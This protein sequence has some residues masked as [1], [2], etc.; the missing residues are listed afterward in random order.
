MSYS[1]ETAESLQQNTNKLDSL[2]QLIKDI[3]EFNKK[4]KRR[5]KKKRKESSDEDN[6]EDLW[7]SNKTKSKG[8]KTGIKKNKT[9]GNEEAM[10]KTSAPKK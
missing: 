7:V 3:N 1:D 4:N 8:T 10:K 5:G 2:A 9:E 6:V